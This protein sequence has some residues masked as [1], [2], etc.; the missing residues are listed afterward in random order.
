MEDFPRKHLAVRAGYDAARR[1][2]DAWRPAG[3]GSGAAPPEAT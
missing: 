1:T 2:L 3:A